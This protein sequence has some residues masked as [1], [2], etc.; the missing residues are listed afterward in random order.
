MSRRVHD[1]AMLF[2][3]LAYASTLDPRRPRLRDRIGVSF[4]EAFW[5][6]ALALDPNN[7]RQKQP[8]HKQRQ[9]PRRSG[10]GPFSLRR[11]LDSVLDLLQAE[12]HLVL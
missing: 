2:K 3:P 10:R 4:V 7:R 11:G 8:S 5:S 9:L 12:H 1:A 6:P